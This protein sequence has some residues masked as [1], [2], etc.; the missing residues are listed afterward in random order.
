M[1]LARIFRD[2]Q[3][4]S[5]HR[6][7]ETQKQID[8]DLETPTVYIPVLLPPSSVQTCAQSASAGTASRRVSGHENEY[9]GG[10]QLCIPANRY[11]GL[12]VR[13]QS[14]HMGCRGI[15]RGLLHR[16]PLSY[17]Q[18]S[19]RVEFFIG[20]PALM[21]TRRRDVATDENIK[22]KLASDNDTCRDC[23]KDWF[24]DWTRR[25]CLRD[26]E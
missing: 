21:A 1:R 3:L 23:T 13:S 25:G 11:S 10:N 2:Q 6:E 12:R 7:S 22:S 24:M 14:Q 15:V 20:P 16:Q 8:R 5:W 4:G 26:D 9:L 19:S 18:S 17:L